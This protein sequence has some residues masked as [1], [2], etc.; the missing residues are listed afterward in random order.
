MT[1]VSKV[2]ISEKTRKKL[3]TLVLTFLDAGNLKTRE[4]IF[5]EIFTKTERLMFAKRLGILLLIE[6]GCSL[7]EVSTKLGVSP[8]T[9]ARFEIKNL[10]GQHAITRKWLKRRHINNQLLRL[11]HELLSIPFKRSYKGVA[12]LIKDDI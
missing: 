5:R 6:Q 11:L 3:D 1:H 12:P 9:A 4:H 7:Y 8:S 2:P 10:R